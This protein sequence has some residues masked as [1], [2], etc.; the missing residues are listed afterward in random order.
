M[1]KAQKVYDFVKNHF[2]WNEYFGAYTDVGIKKAVDDKTGNVA[3]INL[4]LIAA[5]RE[6]DLYAEPVMLATRHVERPGEL[7][8]VLNDFNYVVAKMNVG[9]KYY[10]LD[11]V[12]D[13]LPFGLIS[14][15]CYNGKGRVIAEG[16]SYWIE[17]KPA[18]RSRIVTQVTLKLSTEGMLTGNVTHSYYGY[19]AVD[20]RKKIVSFTDEKSY[21]ADAKS[22][23]HIMEITAYDR[24]VEAD[25]SKPITE[26]FAVEINAFDSPG[27]SHFLFNPFFNGRMETNPFKTEKRNFPVDFGVPVER[28]LIVTVEYPDNVEV[29]S[30][31][32]KI[33]L[34]LPN[35]GGRYIYSALADGKK[36]T[37]SNLMSIAKPIYQPEEYPYLRELYAKKI[38]TEN[39][40]IIFQKKK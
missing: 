36:L 29:T 8:P 17:L 38:Q 32:D 27:A 28:N 18:D 1:K 13:F 10:L 15:F 23:N 5:L 34:A 25:L 2:T 26:T 35:A 30:V 6:A 4:A 11:A 40:D 16:G 21:V 20:Q 22:N 39:T 9:D 7:H 33:G 19:A 31:P 24:T 3:D 37:I 14:D 12:D